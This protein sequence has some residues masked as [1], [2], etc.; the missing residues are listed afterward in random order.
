M[1][2][3]YGRKRKFGKVVMN[4]PNGTRN[5]TIEK[6]QKHKE[7][8]INKNLYDYYNNGTNNLPFVDPMELLRATIKHLNQNHIEAFYKT[9]NGR[10]AIVLSSE[11][12]KR[13]YSHEINF[14]E[15][16]QNEI[17]TFCLLPKPYSNKGQG[18]QGTIE[19]PH[20]IFVTMYLPTAVSNIAAKKAFMEFGEVHTAFSGRFKET[21]FKGICNRKRHIH[22]TPFK[23]K[24]DLPHEIQFPD[25]DIFPC[26]VD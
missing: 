13:I 9:T 15:Q 11:E 7:N 12:Q 10:F 6:E 2:E 1:N 26:D 5:Y 21:D 24:H 18:R 23:S 3:R 25:D 22:L 14:C 17:L 8:E 19:D 20:T 16:T 4:S